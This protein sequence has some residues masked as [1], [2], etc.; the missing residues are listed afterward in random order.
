MRPLVLRVFSSEQCLGVRPQR[1]RRYRIN[2]AEV[3]TKRD[4]FILE[5]VDFILT[6]MDNRPTGWVEVR[7]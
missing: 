1:R 5:I 2:H 3:Y 6:L 7:L 4:G